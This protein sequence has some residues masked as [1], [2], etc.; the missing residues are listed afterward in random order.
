MNRLDHSVIKHDVAKVII[1]LTN[2]VNASVKPK[3]TPSDLTEKIVLICA[4]LRRKNGA[5]E[6]EL[7]DLEDH[8]WFCDTAVQRL[9]DI[10]VK[11]KMIEI[12][13]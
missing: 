13:D 11:Y 10:A 12:I 6:S 3:R 7:T 4:D 2:I 1:D 5:L 9:K 8:M